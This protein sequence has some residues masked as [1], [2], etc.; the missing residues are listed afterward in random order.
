MAN[1]LVARPGQGV[2]L[3][4][5]T[6]ELSALVNGSLQCVQLG[7]GYILYCNH[8]GAEMDLPTNPYFSRGIVKGPFVISKTGPDGGNV[9]LNPN[10]HAF[11][12]KTF[13]QNQHGDVT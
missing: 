6:D 3:Q 13:I 9:G 8:D 2:T 1:V 7:N 12:L 4:P 10:D 11:V 5:F